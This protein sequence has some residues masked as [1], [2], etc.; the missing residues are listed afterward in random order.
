MKK[1]YMSGCGGMLGEAFYSQFKDDYHLKC[2][3][4]DVNEKW[5]SYC[6]IKD[7]KEYFSQV[8]DFNPDYLFHLGALTDLEYCELHRL[9]AIIINQW[10]TS[11]ATFIA[12][13]L[14]IPL[15]YISTAGIFDGKKDAYD[16]EDKPNPK[17]IYGKTK[18]EGEMIVLKDA[19]KHLVCRAAWMMGGGP[20]K[21][22]SFI[23]LILK[24]IK[25]GKKTLRIVNDKRGT[26][27][28]THDFAKNVKLLI[29]SKHTGLFNIVNRGNTSRLEIVKE[30]IS[31]L[32]LEK[33]IEILEVSSDYFKDNYHAPRPDCE[34]LINKRLDKLGLNI[35]RS[36]KTALKEYLED[37]Y[38][39]LKGGLNGDK[40][41]T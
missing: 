24:Q 18:Y 40:T 17:S 11:Y 41:K 22:K 33:E 20:E 14:D 36:W 35:M 19:K 39:N 38:S 6:D 23:H 13:E 8:M 10:A 28:Y 5:L 25:T 16:E 27:T 34:C 29:E 32:R 31:I 1:I 12:D 2:T 21:D 15:L 4:I 3:D 30:I 9:E 26:I 7:L 37:Y